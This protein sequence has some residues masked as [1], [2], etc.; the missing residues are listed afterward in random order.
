MAA[1]ALSPNP[2]RSVCEYVC[3]CMWMNVCTERGNS[4]QFATFEKP[5]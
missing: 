4:T 2:V 5:N 3:A 1:S